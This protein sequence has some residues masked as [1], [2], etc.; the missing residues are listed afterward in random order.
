MGLLGHSHFAPPPSGHLL[1]AVITPTTGTSPWGC[2]SS[3]RLTW[4]G[5]TNPSRHPDRHL[6]ISQAGIWKNFPGRLSMRSGQPEE[7]VSASKRPS[8]PAPSPP[9]HQPAVCTG[10]RASVGA[11]G[12]AG[13]A[14]AAVCSAAPGPLQRGSTQEGSQCLSLWPEAPCAAG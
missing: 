1:A 8:V 7:R 4:P 13:F 2:A 10:G 9:G 11:G 6:S 3:A 5:R 12:G 14:S